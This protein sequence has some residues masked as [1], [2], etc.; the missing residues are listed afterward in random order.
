M[1]ENDNLKKRKREEEGIEND[2][3]FAPII[4]NRGELPRPNW[5]LNRVQIA[6]APN[7]PQLPR[8]NRIRRF[9]QGIALRPNVARRLQYDQP[10]D[11][12]SCEL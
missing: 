5:D 8:H 3:T 9:P 7:P 2:N 11:Q 1:R 12:L 10:F 4:H 6:I